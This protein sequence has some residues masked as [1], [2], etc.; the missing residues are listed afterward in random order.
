MLHCYLTA[1]DHQAHAYP[2]TMRSSPLGAVLNSDGVGSIVRDG[3]RSFA[4]A[5]AVHGVC[6]S[7]ACVRRGFV[8][9]CDSVCVRESLGVLGLPGVV[10]ACSFSS[11]L[12]AC[13]RV[14]V[15][16]VRASFRGCEH[17]RVIASGLRF[18]LLWGRVPLQCPMQI[19]I[20]LELGA[21]ALPPVTDTQTHTRGGLGSARR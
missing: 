21:G 10:S 4:R 12:C 8:C 2:A 7:R 9:V 20:F 16:R 6:C 18:T 11:S 5:C 15:Y 13:D 14:T 1:H 19:S 17:A 3:L